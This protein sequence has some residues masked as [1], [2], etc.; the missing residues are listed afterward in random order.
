[1]QEDGVHSEDL[2]E[3]EDIIYEAMHVTWSSRLPLPPGGVMKY[4]IKT[5]EIR[6]LFVY[7]TTF[8]ARHQK[9]FAKLLWKGL[10]TFLAFSDSYVMLSCK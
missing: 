5:A 2:I 1:M 7:L 9:V 6:S 4:A 3:M 10:P 8:L